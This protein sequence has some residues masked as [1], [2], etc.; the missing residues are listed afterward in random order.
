MA[1]QELG[2][3]RRGSTSADAAVVAGVDVDIA[4]ARL[5]VNVAAGA[6]VEV[7]VTQDS[8]AAG[9]DVAQGQCCCGLHL[10]WWRGTEGG[11]RPG[12][13]CWGGSGAWLEQ[14]VDLRKGWIS[15]GC[16][17]LGRLEERRRRRTRLLWRA[18]FISG[19]FRAG[20]TSIWRRPASRVLASELAWSGSLGGADGPASGAFEEE[21]ERLAGVERAQARGFAL[22]LRWPCCASA[23]GTRAFPAEAQL[24]RASLA[25]VTAAVAAGLRRGRR[26]R[27]R[28]MPHMDLGVLKG[29]TGIREKA[30]EKLILKQELYCGKLLSSYKNMVAVVSDLVKASKSMRCFI[31]GSAASSV[32]QFS[33]TP[34]DMSDPGDGDGIP[35]FTHFSISEFEVD[36]G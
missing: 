10:W 7:D 33:D 8:A 35:V 27:K 3:G 23:A 20:R 2:A 32:L 12:Q 17:G 9:V 15:T 31:K 5:G 1:V 25:G 24:G 26:E 34:G 16:K 6:N 36:Y 18:A 22:A 29:M 28:Y 11:A 14:I 4:A 21:R 19:N 30:C 13:C